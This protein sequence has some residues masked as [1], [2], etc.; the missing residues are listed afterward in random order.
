MYNVRNLIINESQGE[1]Y[2]LNNMEDTEATHKFN[3]LM[4]SLDYS[5]FKIP[6]G[7]EAVH[8][9]QHENNFMVPYNDMEKLCKTM[10]IDTFT[11]A[12]ELLANHYNIP[13]NRIEIGINEFCADSIAKTTEDISDAILA[14]IPAK[15]STCWGDVYEGSSEGISLKLMYG[16]GCSLICDCPECK[17]G[18]DSPSY[19]SQIDFKTA[20]FIKTIPSSIIKTDVSMVNVYQKDFDYYVELADVEQYMRSEGIDSIKEAVFNIATHNDID[21][22]SITLLCEEIKPK[23]TKEKSEDMC[24]TLEAMNMIAASNVDDLNLVWISKY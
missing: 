15:R 9:I 16:E 10:H 4:E 20:K 22:T 7:P 18:V 23:K 6:F 14:N 1:S 11:E 24:A 3:E 21:N 13:K 8:M 17:K 12:V 5:Y 19:A 2:M